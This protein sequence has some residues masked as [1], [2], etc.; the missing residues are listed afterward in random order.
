MPL[1]CIIPTLCLYGAAALLALSLRRHPDHA[2]VRYAGRC[3]LLGFL[4]H[5]VYLPV[6][7]WREG[8]ASIGRHRGG[9]LL[10]VWVLAGLTVWL[11]RRA[12]WQGL[13]PL[14]YAVVAALALPT[15]LGGRSDSASWISAAW[16]LIPVH[17][18]GAIVAVGIFLVSGLVGSCY[19]WQDRALKMRR[20]TPQLLR[21]PSLPSVERAIT[22][23]M[24]LGF[25]ALTLTVGT[26]VIL[27]GS[28]PSW[29]GSRSHGLLSLLGWVLYGFLLQ[30]RVRRWQPGRRWVF[31]ALLGLAVLLLSFVEIH[32]V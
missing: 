32:G 9:L 20:P 4:L 8:A 17:V 10:L 23:L 24:L 2:G 5:T 6:A 21:F 15:L 7:I 27:G 16:P 11:T 12:R 31:F 29:L 30:S 13:A 1:I 28:A 3:F 26:G 14:L 18:A 25:I 22:R 19:V